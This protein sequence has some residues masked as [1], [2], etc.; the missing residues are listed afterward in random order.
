MGKLYKV[1]EECGAYL[2]AGEICDCKWE[3]DEERLA[4]FR[5]QGTTEQTSESRSFGEQK[6]G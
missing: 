2:D 1:C 4:N 6:A 5:K 3:R